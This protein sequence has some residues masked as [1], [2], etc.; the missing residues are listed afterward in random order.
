MPGVQ[1]YLDPGIYFSQLQWERLLIWELAEYLTL[2][3]TKRMMSQ[4]GNVD[5]A[6]ERGALAKN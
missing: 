5:T 1:I 3:I 2:P 4:D 6:I